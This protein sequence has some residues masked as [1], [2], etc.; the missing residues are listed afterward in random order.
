MESAERRLSTLAS[1]ANTAHDLA[2]IT[3]LQ[4]T[5][6]TAL[7]RLDQGIEICLDYLRR[8]GMDWSAHP[9]S[10]EVQREY[11]RIWSLLGNRQ[12]ENLVDGPL[13]T[14]PDTLD[15]FEVLTE[16]ITPAVFFDHNLC[17]FVIFR[18]VNL[19]LEH[20][21]TDASSFAYVWFAMI[22]ASRF[23]KCED[24]VRFG[25][26]GY[27]SEEHTSELQSPMYLVCRLLL[28]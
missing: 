8:D 11:D 17:A 20:G 22:S 7:D 26:L 12:I 9:A 2:L 13:V 21:N 27:R 24:A 5:L 6:Y 1:C 28:E 3:C 16:L 15:V 25:Q 23:G 10:D 4:L 19:S 18:L 14:D